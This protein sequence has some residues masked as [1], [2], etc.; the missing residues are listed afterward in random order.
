MGSTRIVAAKFMAFAAVSL[1]LLALL[2]NTMAGG[3]GGKQTPYKAVFVDVNG[4][5]SGDDI[6]VAG[7]KVGEVTSISV[8][9]GMARIGFDVL[10]DHLPSTTT[11]LVLR[12]QNLIGQRYVAMVPGKKPGSALGRGATVPAARTSPG[13]DLTALLNGFRPLFQVLKPADVNALSAS[14]IKVLQGE[15]GTVAGLLQQTAELTNYVADRDQLF[16]E[17]AVNLTPLLQQISGDGSQIA[18]TVSDLTQLTSGLAKD[19]NTL[20]GSLD[21]LEAVLGQ[22]DAT[23]RE[24]R[25]PLTDDIE[26]LREVVGLYAAHSDA[27]GASFVHF[28]S[29]LDALGRTASYHGGL[30]MLMCN[31]SLAL[32]KVTVPVGVPNGKNSEVCR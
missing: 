26:K 10:D 4:L 14:I 3:V 30:T 29:L 8:V 11:G 27:Y 5:R 17:V 21:G 22:T 25:A 2:Y 24:I 15:G 1:V 7:V 16:H 6:R 28:G 18:S 9:N 23:V 20:G 31:I 32:D 12:Y 19:K 13:F